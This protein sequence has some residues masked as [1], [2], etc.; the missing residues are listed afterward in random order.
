MFAVKIKIGLIGSLRNKRLAACT[1][2]SKAYML[3]TGH[4]IR[5]LVN[6]SGLSLPKNRGEVKPSIHISLTLVLYTEPNTTHHDFGMF[7]HF[8]EMQDSLPYICCSAIAFELIGY[9][10]VWFSGYGLFSL[11]E[12]GQSGHFGGMRLLRDSGSQF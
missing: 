9:K 6:R 8:N 10:S 12:I 2:P 1:A 4:L 3:L 7:S 11:N 5:L